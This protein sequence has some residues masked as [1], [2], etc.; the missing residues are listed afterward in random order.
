MPEIEFRFDPYGAS[1]V[2]VENLLKWIGEL[3]GELTDNG[4]WAELDTETH[5]QLMALATEADNRKVG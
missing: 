1:N 3:H 5:L 2:T 4:T